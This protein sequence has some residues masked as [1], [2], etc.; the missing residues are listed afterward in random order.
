MK[1]LLHDTDPILLGRLPLLGVLAPALLSMQ[2]IEN[3]CFSCLASG[4]LPRTTQLARPRPQR[5]APWYGRSGFIH[6]AYT[7]RGRIVTDDFPKDH[8]HQHGI[9]FA[10]TSARIDD[11]AV[12]FWNSHKQQGRVEHVETVSATADSIVVDL[13]HVDDTTGEPRVALNERWKIIRV[14]H[15]SMNVFDL[16]STQTCVTAQPIVIEE[17]HYGA[18]CVRGSAAWSQDVSMLTSGGQRRVTGNHARAKWVAMSGYVG[19]ETCGIAA[20]CHPHNFRGPA[21]CQAPP[22]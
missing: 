10:W 14:P 20:M 3:N 15:P 12:D 5:E 6:P 18:M 16:A 8:L 17:Y 19:G 1:C 2:K 11:R 22:R 4:R 21:T 7:P 13:Q 9:M